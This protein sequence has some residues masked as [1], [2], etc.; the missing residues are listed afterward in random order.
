MAQ[1][2]FLN[3]CSHLTG[4]VHPEIAAQA[5]SDLIEAILGIKRILPR[6]SLVTSEP[7]PSLRLGN[8]YSVA[9]WLNQA[10][11][12]R[13]RVRFLLSL[14]QQAPFR[15]VRTILGDRD[16]GVT[17]YRNAGDV[18]EGVGLADLYGGVPVSFCREIRWRAPILILEVEQLLEDDERRWSTEIRHV[19]LI[20]HV[21]THRDWLVSLRRR[22]V[23]NAA[24]L[25]LNKAELLPRIEFGPRIEGDLKQLQPPAFFQVIRYLDR[26]NDSVER[27]D[28]ETR[29]APEYPP[30]TS[31]ESATRKPLCVFP[32]LGGGTAAFTWHGRYTPTAGRIHFRVEQN[33]KRAIIG[34]IGKKL[35]I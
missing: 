10:G 13:E 28:P 5:M 20:T 30:N 15:V 2:M 1:L 23:Q 21:E 16:P 8:S 19:S 11:I 34:Y 35:G 14:G 18:V 32:T 25:C 33:P 6:A 26:L 17:V 9:I 22:D 3:E 27:W 31:D 24:D 12:A 4:D 29:P 7:L